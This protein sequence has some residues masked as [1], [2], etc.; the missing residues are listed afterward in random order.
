MGAAGLDTALREIGLAHLVGRAAGEIMAGILDA[1]AGPGSTVDDEAARAA[2]AALNE[3]LLREAV[4]A[5][6]VGR[7]LTANLDAQGLAGILM[8]FFSLYIYERF[9]RDFYERWVK[10]SGS[11]ATRNGLRSVRN[12]IDSA[13]GSKM[14]GRDVSRVE[15]QG[16]EG[17]QAVADVLADTCHVFGVPT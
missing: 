5:D 7:L 8:R 6:D 9:C 10:A 13:L 17:R 1:L 4:S 3:D 16:E 14:V 2:L 11:D 15:W 12:Y